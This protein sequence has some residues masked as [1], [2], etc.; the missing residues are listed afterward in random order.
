MLDAEKIRSTGA[1]DR[2]PTV[3]QEVAV[4]TALGIGPSCGVAAVAIAKL[5]LPATPASIPTITATGN[6]RGNHDA[7]SSMT[8]AMA[9]AAL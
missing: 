4:C 3:G 2:F 1:P 8:T 9:A 6:S 7:A 5:A